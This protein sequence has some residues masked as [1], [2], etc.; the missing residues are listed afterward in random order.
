[1]SYKV[2]RTQEGCGGWVYYIEDGV[3][4]PFDWE[5]SATGFDI[6][7]PSPQEWDTF[8]ARHGAQTAFGRRQEVLQ[9]VAEE[10]RRKK[11]KTAKVVIDDAG[12]S[13]SFKGDPVYTLLR[14]ILGV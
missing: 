9:R 12:I 11:A 1:M 14:K 4:L 5:Y 6:Y 8:C 13:F 2:E 3:K 10:V 7:A